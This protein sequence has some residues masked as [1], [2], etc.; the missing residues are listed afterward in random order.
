MARARAVTLPNA[1]VAVVGLGRMGRRHVQA[2]RSI[3][4]EVSAICD[5]SPESLAS[6]EREL[7]IGPDRQYRDLGQ[8]LKAS[9]PDVLVVATTAPTHAEY[10]CAAAE[11]GV[12]AIL[13]EKPMAVSLA[14]CD[15]MRDACRAHGAKLAINHQMR[16]MEQYVLP[17]A[18]VE[19]DAF[20]GLR[21]VTVVAGNFGMS[22]NALHYFE[23][24]RFMTGER[25]CRVTAWFSDA[26]VPNPRGAEFQDRAGAVRL[27]T[28]TGRRFYLD[29]GADQ[30]HGMEVIYA[31]PYGHLYV[32]ELAGVLHRTVREEAHRALPTTRYGMPALRTTH[33][34]APADVVEP[35]AAVLQAL[36][37]GE[38]YPD[39]DD[40]RLAVAVLVAAYLS[41]ERG[42]LT[43]D[44][45]RDALPLDRVF[46]WA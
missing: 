22:M 9:T 8:M 14:E 40:G 41:H 28:A 27:E 46:P 18:M 4:L 21:S 15:R 29:C 3:G 45:D 11:A 19:S 12:K 31:G 36:V 43:I 10:T 30:G 20:G 25:P 17:K 2:V 13:C 37:Q 35:S 1:N 33:T 6:A 26:M 34:I 32:D 44:L 7:A 39:G 38:N 23:M 5:I 42:H 16:F 24:F